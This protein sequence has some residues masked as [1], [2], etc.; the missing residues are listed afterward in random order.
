MIANNVSSYPDIALASCTSNI[1]PNDMS[2]DLG[3]HVRSTSHTHMFTATVARA[4]TPQSPPR[5]ASR[6]WVRF[7]SRPSFSCELESTLGVVRP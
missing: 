4:A 2:N 6:F 1:L 5:L 3:P 7:Q